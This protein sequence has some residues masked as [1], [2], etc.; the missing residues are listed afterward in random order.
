MGVGGGGQ[1]LRQPLLFLLSRIVLPAGA[2]RPG[3]TSIDTFMHCRGRGA[4]VPPI[5]DIG[6]SPTKI[7][8]YSYW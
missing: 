2:G 5:H 1:E 4:V 3:L 8:S 6:R 7:P